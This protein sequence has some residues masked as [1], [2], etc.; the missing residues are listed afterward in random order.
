[1][2]APH[3]SAQRLR[4]RTQDP[5]TYCWVFFLCCVVWTHSV[6]QTLYPIA[7]LPTK[8]LQIGMFVIQAEIASTP[9]TRTQ[10]LMYRTQLEPNQGMLFIFDQP[11]VQC[12]WMKNTLIPLTAAFINDQGQIVNMADMTPQTDTP[13]C[14]AQPVRYVLEMNQGWFTQRGIQPGTVVRGIVR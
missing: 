3:T 1:M 14:S 4:V 7:T 2:I 6:A 12:F 8:P 11:G 10:G 13:H 5:I 9:F